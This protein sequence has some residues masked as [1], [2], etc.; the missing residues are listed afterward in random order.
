MANK[1]DVKPTLPPYL[2][3]KTFQSFVQR[4][5][6]TT[7]P[8]R[9]DSTL[10]RSY[11]GSIA[12]KLRGTLRFLGLIDES[13]TTTQ[14]LRMLASVFSTPDWQKSLGEVV[15]DAYQELT[16]GLELGA[17]TRGQLEERFTAYGAEGDV[18]KK[19]LAFYVAAVTAG[20]IALSPH[21]TAERRGRPVQSRGRKR[22]TPDESKAQNKSWMGTPPRGHPVMAPGTIQFVLPLPGKP[23][24]TIIVAENLT[25]D[26]WVMVQS[27][28]QAYIE[29]RAKEQK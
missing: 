27:S 4:L 22:K 8:P 25:T 7:V 3:F 10:F 21:I 16:S 9:V 2:P 18:L 26:D 24:V 23:P 15:S 20:G 6:E 17:C 19:C 28:M 11:S 12:S 1:N 14:K 13:D 5:H 29:R